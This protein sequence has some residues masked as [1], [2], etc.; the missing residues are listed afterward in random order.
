MNLLISSTKLAN[1]ARIAALAVRANQRVPI[2]GCC[3]LTAG[4]NRGIYGTDLDTADEALALFG[5]FPARRRHAILSVYA[6]IMRP[7]KETDL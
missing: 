1:A 2:L 3:R 5:K 7:F 6:A 4:D